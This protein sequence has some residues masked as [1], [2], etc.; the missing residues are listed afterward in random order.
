MIRC[1]KCGA[2]FEPQE[3]QAEGE[4]ISIIRLLPVFGKDSRLVFEYVELFG[5]SPLR[6]KG[7]KILRLLREVT[8]LFEVGKFSYQK[9]EYSVS[10]AGIMEGLSV[11]CNKS[12]TAPLEGHNYLKKVLIGI[13]EREQKD[14]RDKADAD[15]RR[16][17]Q[18]TGKNN[19][20]QTADNRL[21]KRL[22]GRSLLKNMVLTLIG[23][24]VSLDD[25]RQR[26]D[27]S[28]DN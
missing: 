1:T 4:W 28:G 13:S 10:R 12:F 21:V 3:G 9:K 20:Q 11:V 7:K 25:R 23:S 26:T 16:R 5:I 24:G 14:T 22:P 19:R 6:M 27:V 2:S 17:A 15:Q 18:G 8:K